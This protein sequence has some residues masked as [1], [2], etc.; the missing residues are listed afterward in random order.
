MPTHPD[1][2]IDALLD[3]TQEITNLDDPMSAL[4][5]LLRRLCHLLGAE[6]A[7]L[8]VQD[9]PRRVVRIAVGHGLREPSVIGLEMPLGVGLLGRT[10]ATGRSL[11]L[12]AYTDAPMI[13]Q[14]AELREASSSER[15]M[16]AIGAPIGARGRT[17][18]ALLV[19][20]REPRAWGDDDVRLVERF[21]TLASMIVRHYF[22][23][24]GEATGEAPGSWHRFIN[25]R[26]WD[27]IHGGRATSFWEALERR[28][29]CGV[30]FLTA[31]GGID[32][33]RLPPAAVRDAWKLS[34][35]FDRAVLSGETTAIEFDGQR[36]W[37]HRVD[38]HDQLHGVLSIWK[39]PGTTPVNQYQVADAAFVTS[40]HLTI[41]RL[42]TTAAQR[43]ELLLLEQL[44]HGETLGGED[45]GERLLRYGLRRDE[46]CTVV[47]IDAQPAALQSVQRVIARELRYQ[48]P[49][50]AI[51]G[52]HLCLLLPG[53]LDP[54]RLQRLHD[55][56]VGEGLEAFIAAEE[57]EGGPLRIQGAHELARSLNGSQRALGR[58]SG[59]ATTTT[60]GITGLLYSAANSSLIGRIV[61]ARLGPMLDYDAARG[62]ELERTAWTFL[63][64]GRRS[65]DTAEQLHIH[66]NTLR[67]R[68]ERID[69][70]LGR[71]WREAPHSYEMFLALEARRLTDAA[72]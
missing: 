70:L 51:H 21:A 61:R 25:A 53:P 10:C 22:N 71:E 47:R 14:S 46:T 7:V 16:S 19:G 62:T 33:R 54:P 52:K 56:L 39:E 60:F 64:G 1:T 9:A 66:Q 49:L 4:R 67:Q 8:G 32:G 59:V 11:A 37:L 44:L 34:S 40:L 57:C 31:D 35:G 18:A 55:A 28:L 43:W 17:V 3:T 23:D 2:V 12:P 42:E 38:A 27:A 68:L 48:R 58:E 69:D 15:L 6:L 5:G 45:S 50:L 72:D 26:R 13:E 63:A 36:C 30:T 20:D 65:A 24:R 41:D 29:D